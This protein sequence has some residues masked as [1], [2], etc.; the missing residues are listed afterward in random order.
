MGV[1]IT[2]TSDMADVAYFIG[3]GLALTD[4]EKDNSYLN[5]VMRAAF[6]EAEE[7]FNQEAIA[8]GRAGAI[9]HMFEWGTVGINRHKTNMRPNPN[10]DVARLWETVFEGSGVHRSLSYYYRPS[11][12]VVPKPTTRETG[13]S[14]S[15]I[16]MLEDHVFWNKAQV[17]EEGWQV[18]ISP[19]NSKFLILPFYKGV[20]PAHAKPSDVKRGYTMTRKT[21]TLRPGNNVAGNFTNFWLQFWEGRGNEHVQRSIIEQ[22]ERDY[23]YSMQSDAP[24]QITMPQTFERMIRERMRRLR[25]NAKR[26]ARRAAERMRRLDNK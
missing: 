5:D 11:V 26:R 12:A 6:G 16:S 8:L 18:H 7:M 10:S 3:N 22:I 2:V 9:S 4:V 20:I 23:M 14:Q 1:G 15:D 13:M 21:V 24:P 25:Y 17:F 19:V